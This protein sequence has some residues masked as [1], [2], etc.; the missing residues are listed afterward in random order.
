MYSVILIDDEPVILEGLKR[1]I[2]WNEYGFED[3][4]AVQVRRKPWNLW[5]P[6]NL[7]SVLPIIRMH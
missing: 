7:T 1:A 2:P 5:A 3:I 4:I 6:N